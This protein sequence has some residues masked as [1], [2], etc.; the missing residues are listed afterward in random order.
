MSTMQ[1]R[2]SPPIL[3]SKLPAFYG[4][5]ADITF[6]ITKAVSPA[7]FQKVRVLI[8]TVQNNIIKLDKNFDT[9]Y[10]DV[11]SQTYHVRINLASGDPQF[12]KIGQHY[13][14]QLA[15][16]DYNDTIG[17]YSSVGVM[18]CT[19]KPDVCIKELK[20][21]EDNQRHVYTY[22]GLYTHPGDITEKAYSYCFNL[23]DHKGDLVS[24]SGELIHDN[25]KDKENYQSTDTWTIRK[26][27]DTNVHYQI[28]YIVT[29]INGLRKSSPRYI[30]LETAT[31]KPNVHA[32]LHCSNS[33]DDGYITCQLKGD[34]SGVKVNGRFILMRSS[35]EDH[36]ESWY[37]LTRFDLTNWSSNTDLTICKDYTTQLGVK[38]IYAIRAYNSAGLFSD[39][40]T[41]VE[42]EIL[43]DFEDAF[44]YDGERQLKIR[45]NPKVSSF[46]STILESKTDTL[47]GKYPF[48]FRNGDVCYK[49]FSIS[50]LISLLADENNEFLTNL[51]PKPYEVQ[52]EMGHWLTADNIRKEREFKMA[53]L[54]WLTNGKPKLFRSPAEGN[55]I[56]YLMNTSLT[57]NDTLNRVLHTFQSTAYEIAEF[58]F[59][60]LKQY[61]FMLDDYTETRTLKIDTYGIEILSALEDNTIFFERQASYV[62]IIAHPRTKFKYLLVGENESKELEIGLTGHYIFSPETLAATPM[63]KLE[64]IE[65]EWGNNA[66][67][68]YGWYDLTADNFSI[69]RKITAHDNIE[70]IPGKG[71]KYNILNDLE[72]IRRKTG[73]FHYLKIEPKQIVQI[74]KVSGEYYWNSNYLPVV[75]SELNPTMIYLIKEGFHDDAPMRFYLDGA[76]GG[77]ASEQLISSIDYNFF[78]TGVREGTVVDF[79]GRFSFED[80]TTGR[81]EAL[82][83][84]S[85]LTKLV[86]GNGIVL[87]L[88]Y[89]SQTIEYIVEDEEDIYASQPVID[90]K[91]DWEQAIR[92]NEAGAVPDHVVQDT[93]LRYV[94]LLTNALHALSNHWEDVEY[95]L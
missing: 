72:D 37:E 29:T 82:T 52:E 13:K 53:V 8:K 41:N 4:T 2:L 83:N 93:Y 74:Y 42:G 70:Q 54:S 87:D 14:V 36:Y 81:Y 71:I 25:S 47:G 66:S 77:A 50:G 9:L 6:S 20:E 26:N 91:H 63:I 32:T 21:S 90:A 44:L 39:R 51:P 10:R 34:R 76:D 31:T 33:F 56:I 43:A 45:F 15:L 30:I 22:T 24:T 86:A 80:M 58:N 49:E 55:F 89:Q 78:I 16:V 11:K 35:S 75:K 48:I 84:L 94:Q 61:G 62:S 3:E 28:E 5:E 65:G 38:Y 46:K 57:P 69:I 67:V 7:D 79:N 85:G 23:Y 40:L 73:A 59:D 68:T 12:P 64:K 18:K 27:L 1:E 17:Y 60:N 88:V 95:A 92:G 19:V